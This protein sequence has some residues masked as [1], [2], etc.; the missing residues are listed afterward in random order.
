M[1]GARIQLSLFSSGVD[2]SRHPAA[3]IQEEIMKK[4]AL[5]VLS[6]S[7]AI[8]TFAGNVVGHSVAAAGKDSAKVAALAGKDSGKAAEVAGKDSGKAVVV[9]GKDTG[10]ATAKAVKFLF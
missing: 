1:S 5:I 4:V 3:N 6:I 10:K 7:M 2:G 8:P 9:A